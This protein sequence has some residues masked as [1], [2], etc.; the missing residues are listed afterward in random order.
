M[1]SIDKAGYLGSVTG[2]DGRCFCKTLETVLGSASAHISVADDSH[3]SQAL[4][5]LFLKC[6][7]P[8][9]PME[10]WDIHVK[11]SIP[12]PEPLSHVRITRGL[13]LP[14]HKILTLQEDGIAGRKELIIFQITVLQAEASSRHKTAFS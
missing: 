1:K 13:H 12:I 8:L 2:G 6:I 7:T 9:W 4:L 10:L 3:T 11:P 14:V 5:C